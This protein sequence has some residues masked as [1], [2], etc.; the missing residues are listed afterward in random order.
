MSKSLGTGIDPLDLSRRYGADGVRFGLLAMSSAQDVRFSEEKIA[1]GQALANKL[2][3]ASRLV[4]LRRRPGRASRPRGRA[5]SR[6]AGSSR[7]CSA[8]SARSTRAHRRRSTSPT[9]RWRSTTSS[10]ASCATGTS[11]SSSR[12]STTSATTRTSRPT[13]LHVLARDAGARPSDD[14]V[15]DR[16][17]LVLRARRR[18]PAGRRTRGATSRAGAGRRRG[19]GA[20]SARAIAAVQALRGWRDEV[21]A[22]PGP[23]SPARLAADGY[24]RD[25]RRSVARLARFELRVAD[26]A[27]GRPRRSASPAARSR[28]CPADAVDL[29]AARAPARA[30]RARSSSRDRARARA[31]SP[32]RAS[33]PRRRPAVVGRAREAR[34]AARGAR[35]RERRR[36]PGGEGGA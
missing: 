1:Q 17:D 9:P 4:L 30:A 10:T 11:S 16:G 21:G 29:E 8:R 20:G 19:R 18:G 6:T 34:A 14:P 25:G 2:W 22:R 28:C 23:A 27:D 7:A 5:R 15:R 24:E 12:A 26:G 13:L 35:G 36:W 33:S 3:N 31:S 32:T